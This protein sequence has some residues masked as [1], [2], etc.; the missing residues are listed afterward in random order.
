MFEIK[1]PNKFLRQL[2][3]VEF[4]LG[5][6]LIALG[7]FLLIDLYVYIYINRRFSKY[8]V[9]ETIFNVLLIIAGVLKV[10]AFLLIKKS[11]QR[12]LKLSMI[13]FVLLGVNFLFYSIFIFVIDLT[14]VLSG[15]HFLASSIWF[16]L[17]FTLFIISSLFFLTIFK[18]RENLKKQI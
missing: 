9:F 12:G 6:G 7:S 4:I 16:I 2:I 8:P 3:I 11:N 13:S 15:L 10:I 18:N 1:S 5:L 14:R 17:F